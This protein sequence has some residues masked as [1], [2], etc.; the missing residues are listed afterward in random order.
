MSEPLLQLDDV[1]IR[2]GGL[3]AVSGVRLEIGVQE[4]VGPVHQSPPLAIR[5]SP[6]RGI[7]D[8]Q[9]AGVRRGQQRRDGE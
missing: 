3:T 5:Q 9:R 4:L 2:F 6:P 7:G 1:T 8:G